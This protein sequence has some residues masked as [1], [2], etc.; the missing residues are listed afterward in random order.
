M[1]RA[2]AFQGV[3]NSIQVVASVALS[4]CGP[5]LDSTYGAPKVDGIYS[6]HL[7]APIDV[8]EPLRGLHS[9]LS[10]WPGRTDGTPDPGKAV[11]VADCWHCAKLNGTITVRSRCH[12]GCARTKKS[13]KEFGEATLASVKKEM[14]KPRLAMSA[15]EGQ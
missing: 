9:D 2:S 11:S 6:F 3:V 4:S 13:K 15:R 14:V 5:S 1:E 7:L 12:H 10:L 8:G